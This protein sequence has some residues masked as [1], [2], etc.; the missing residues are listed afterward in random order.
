M[1]R[2]RKHNIVIGMPGLTAYSE[3]ISCLV[4][5]LKLYTT[6]DISN[7]ICHHTNAEGSS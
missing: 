3:N 1:S 6:A 4:E 5:T 7:D 2:H